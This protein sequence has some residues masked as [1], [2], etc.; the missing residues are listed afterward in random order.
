MTRTLSSICLTCLIVLSLAWR[1]TQKEQAQLCSSGK[2]W[3]FH[4]FDGKHCLNNSNH[5]CD[6][7][8]GAS[9]PDGSDLDDQLCWRKVA[10]V[11]GMKFSC[12]GG[13]EIFM[14]Y[15]CNGRC[16][17][18]GHNGAQCDDENICKGYLDRCPMDEGTIAAI[19]VGV[20]AA[21]EFVI[22][23]A[24]SVFAYSRLKRRAA[25]QP[26]SWSNT[27]AQVDP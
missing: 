23:I 25:Q 10:G 14:D 6:K 3:G 24:I 11:N 1:S 2:D 9:C 15:V 20:V 8:Q 16:D 5:V 27:A 21:L 7:A 12:C 13:T 22:I 18:P 17:C 4:C 19:A 26:V